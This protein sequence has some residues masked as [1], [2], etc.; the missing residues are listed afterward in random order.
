MNTPCQDNDQQRLDFIA[1][2]ISNDSKRY[3]N[4]IYPEGVGQ[5]IGIPYI[6]DGTAEHTLDIY[7]CRE[8]AAAEDEMIVVVHGGA[9][10]YGTNT[11]DKC[12]GT[13]LARYSGMRVANVNYRLVPDTDIRGSIEDILT[14]ISFLHDNYGIK[15]VHITGDSAG[16][17]L[18][19]ITTLVIVCGQI[20][21]DLDLKVCEGIE[22]GPAG[23][24]CGVYRMEKDTFPAVFFTPNGEVLPDYM[25]DLTEAVRI[26]GSDT[27]P[28][29]LVTGENDYLRE[30]SR[31]MSRVC[32]EI[33]IVNRFFDYPNADGREMQHVFPIAHAYWPESQEVIRFIS[34]CAVRGTIGDCPD[35]K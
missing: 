2:C 12:Y 32:E 23:L 21:E 20:R 33:G 15:K 16:G 28:L 24:I 11:L 27:P 31:V 14:S 26:S 1:R 8:V 34:D 30:D 6:D 5:T 29:V 13:Y 19:L 9:F 22:A 7:E 3:P 35:E 10:V 17:Y 4:D 18:A 25:Y